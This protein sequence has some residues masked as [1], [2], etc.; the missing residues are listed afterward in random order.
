[1][2]I[3]E[4]YIDLDGSFGSGVSLVWYVACRCDRFKIT[5]FVSDRDFKS[6]CSP[7]GRACFASIRTGSLVKLPEGFFQARL[8][9]VCGLFAGNIV[10]I[11]ADIVGNARKKRCLENQD[12]GHKD[13]TDD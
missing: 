3:R 6:A 11:E 10:A 1:M 12:N 2:F 5:A 8:G 7:K 4:I 13:Y 9:Q